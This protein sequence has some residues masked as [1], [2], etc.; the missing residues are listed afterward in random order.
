MMVCGDGCCTVS[1]HRY[2]LLYNRKP[3]T[4]TTTGNS[5]ETPPSARQHPF[6]IGSRVPVKLMFRYLVMVRKNVKGLP[7]NLD[8]I[9]VN[10]LQALQDIAPAQ[11]ACVPARRLP[12]LAPH[13]VELDRLVRRRD[14]NAPL[15]RG[16]RPPPPALDPLARGLVGPAGVGDGVQ[17]ADVADPGDGDHLAAVGPGEDGDAVRVLGLGVAEGRGD[18]ATGGGPDQRGDLRL[19]GNGGERGARV[20]V[21][22]MDGPVVGAAACGHEA[23]L[24]GAER[25]GFD[26]RAVQPFVPLAA[27]GDVEHQAVLAW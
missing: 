27:I 22:E 4:H 2:A 24:P 10:P 11:E 23:P 25:D 18:L 17:G 7:N 14:D 20:G 16:A 12:R 26:G 3:E 13:L 5:K 1:L 8:P 9:L 15:L 21:E 6:K 19:D